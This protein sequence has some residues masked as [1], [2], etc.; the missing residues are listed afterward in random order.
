MALSVADMINYLIESMPVLYESIGPS[1]GVVTG[2]LPFSWILENGQGLDEQRGGR[3]ALLVVTVIGNRGKRKHQ[4]HCR[5][6]K[7]KHLAEMKTL[8][9]EGAD[10]NAGNAHLDRT[11]V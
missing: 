10:D 5:N 8:F 2:R 9:R 4:T 7:W 6:S 11:V 1:H 3:Q